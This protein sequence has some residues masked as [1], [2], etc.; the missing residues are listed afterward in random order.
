VTSGG[1]LRI[2]TGITPKSGKNVA[3]LYFPAKGN[4]TIDKG[5]CLKLEEFYAGCTTTNVEPIA[6]VNFN[7][8]ITVSAYCSKGQFLADQ[9]FEF[10]SDGLVS[11]KMGK[12]VATLPAAKTYR[13]VASILPGYL[14]PIGPELT[15]ALFDNVKTVQY[16]DLL[17]CGKAF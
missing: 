4:L 1:G 5:S 11:S 16:K 2:A 3:L 8:H 7:C 6:N 10:K 17:S 12:F 15:A 9:D 13:F 14:G